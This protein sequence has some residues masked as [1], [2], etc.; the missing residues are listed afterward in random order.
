MGLVAA[1]EAE[2][3]LEAEWRVN[4]APLKPPHKS[5]RRGCGRATIKVTQTS[6]PEA[7]LSGYVTTVTLRDNVAVP[8]PQATSDVTNRKAITDAGAPIRDSTKGRV[9]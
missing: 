4:D 2:G 5:R 7:P 9:L 8:L 3:Y 6:T 1:T